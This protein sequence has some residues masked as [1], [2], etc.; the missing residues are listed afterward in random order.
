MQPDSQHIPPLVYVREGVRLV[1]DVV[2]TQNDVIAGRFLEDSIAL[3]SWKHDVHVVSRTPIRGSDGLLYANN[4]GA[5]FDC[6]L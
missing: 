5:M 1:G 3:G 4:E 2:F 6:M